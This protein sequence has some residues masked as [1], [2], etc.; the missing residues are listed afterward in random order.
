MKRFNQLTPEEQD[1]HFEEAQDFMLKTLERM[2]NYLKILQKWSERVVKTT[3]EQD[4]VSSDIDNYLT[5]ID[6]FKEKVNGAETVEDLKYVGKEIKSFW[7]E[8][9]I[10]L[11]KIVGT[12]LSEKVNNTILRAGRLSVR[13]HDKIDALNQDDNEVKEMQIL[14]SDFDEKV[15]LAKEKYEKARNSYSEIQSLSDANKIF[16]EANKFL[17]EADKYLKNAH[18]DLRSLV[19]LYRS[20]KGNFPTLEPVS[21]NPEDQPS[22]TEEDE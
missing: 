18:K 3:T 15:T 21:Y 6:M 1:I 16:G 8:T 19:K 4:S 11:K 17:R 20:Y 9:R 7:K 22:L 14:I 10:K 12:I 2:E 13:L 5:E